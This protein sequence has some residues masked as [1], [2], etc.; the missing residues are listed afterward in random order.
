MSDLFPATAPPATATVKAISLW[1][2][3][4]SLWLS[5]RKVHETRHWYTQ[6]SGRLAVHAAKR[7]ETKFGPG[8]PLLEILQDEFGGHWAMDLPRGCLLGFVDLVSVAKTERTT[9]AS[10][11]D[12]A[13]GDWTPGRYAWRRGAYAILTTPVAYR[14]LQGMF[15]VP[16]ELLAGEAA[17]FTGESP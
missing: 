13:C 6:H 8:D 4:A 15:S 2:P 17:S 16:E 5:S 11:D 12:R 9:P 3:W 10:D 1:Q 7:C 14:G